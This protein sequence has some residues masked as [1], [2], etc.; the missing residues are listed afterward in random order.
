MIVT[1]SYTAN[2]STLISDSRRSNEIKDVKELSEQNKVSYGAVNNASTFKFFQVS[3]SL[4]SKIYCPF[5][6]AVLLFLNTA[7]IVILF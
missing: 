4:M 1:A 2:L 3:F 6:Q 5:Q 7:F